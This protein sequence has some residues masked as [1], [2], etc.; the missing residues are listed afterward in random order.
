MDD[1]VFVED[2]LGLFIQTVISHRSVF[3]MGAQPMLL[4]LLED[5]FKNG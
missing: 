1:E 2:S 3:V 5:Y 4:S